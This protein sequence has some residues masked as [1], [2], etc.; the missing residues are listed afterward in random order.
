MAVDNALSVTCWCWLCVCRYRIWRFFCSTGSVR[1]SW[2]SP[3][4]NYVDT[5]WK[6]INRRDN[7]EKASVNYAVKNE[8]E[9]LKHWTFW[10]SSSNIRKCTLVC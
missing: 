8:S 7:S 9:P 2:S 4:E 3:N 1:S 5:Q 6:V 10:R